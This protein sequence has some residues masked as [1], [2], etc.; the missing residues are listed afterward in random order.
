MDIPAKTTK[1]VVHHYRPCNEDWY[2]ERLEIGEASLVYIKMCQKLH[3]PLHPVITL[4][5][6]AIAL[7]FVGTI[8][9]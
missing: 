6:V 9:G 5:V 8:Y 7:A 3:S 2:H 1:L 4:V